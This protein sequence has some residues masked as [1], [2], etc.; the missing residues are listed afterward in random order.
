MDLSNHLI[1][2]IKSL[3]ATAKDAAIRSFEHHRIVLYWQIGERIF[4]E[5]QQRKVRT[6]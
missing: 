3:I 1:P 6:E 2:E 5:E 4:N